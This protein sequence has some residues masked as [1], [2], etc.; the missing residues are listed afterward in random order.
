[1]DGN[2]CHAENCVKNRHGGGRH[3]SMHQARLR[4]YGTLEPNLRKVDRRPVFERIMDKVEMITESGCWIFMGT[5]TTHG[6]IHQHGGLPSV[7]VHRA[8]WEHFNGPIPKDMCVCHRC[9]IGFCVNPNHLFLG[10]DLDNMRDK[11]K[12]NR[13]AKGERIGNAKL[14]TEKVIYIKTSKLSAS[15]IA[16]ELG[17]CKSAIKAVRRGV[18]WAHVTV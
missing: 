9:D 18:N 11:V 12:K 17:V 14:T 6:R 1:M 5:A 13:Q 7:P 2:K 3:C 8:V 10:T 15:K 4:I 16:K